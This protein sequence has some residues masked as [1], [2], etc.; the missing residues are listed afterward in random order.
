MA[1]NFHSS[2]TTAAIFEGPYILHYIHVG[3]KGARDKYQRLANR[4]TDLKKS[5]V[6]TAL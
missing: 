3:F 2:C 1:N 5:H 6:K 4:F